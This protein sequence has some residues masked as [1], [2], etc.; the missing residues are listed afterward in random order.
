[1]AFDETVRQAEAAAQHSLFSSHLAGIGFVVVSGKVQDPVQ[2]EDLQFRSQGMQG[3]P[4]LAVSR[5]NGDGK[6]A[7]D[8]M[9]VAGECCG[10][11]KHVGGVVLVAELAVEAA[12]ASIAGKQDGDNAAKLRCVRGLG[13]ECRKS[14]PP[15]RAAEFRL[16]GRIDQDHGRAATE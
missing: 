1:G 15:Q 8:A 6:V 5:V 12:D 2:D 13:E 14:L 9:I 7:G 16:Y 10:K 3:F 11:G 4:R